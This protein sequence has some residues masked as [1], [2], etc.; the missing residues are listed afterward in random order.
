MAESKKRISKEEYYLNI[1]DAVGA[2]GTC[3]RRN[4][5]AIIVKA[6]NIIATGY[7][8][9]PR[10]EANC[11][12]VCKCE[13]EVLNIPSGE[14]YELCKSV[15]AE[16]NCIISASRLD[17]I[18]STLYLSGRDANTGELLNAKPCLMCEKM[19]KN[20]GIARVIARQADGSYMTTEVV[21]DTIMSMIKQKQ[22]N[23]GV[24]SSDTKN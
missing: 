13:R 6:D 12:D 24:I 21:N 19:I 3:L 2:R 17:M 16:Q 23:H 15:H 9:S 20:A 4:Y 14:R 7:T 8:G 11:C 1:A 10:G 22:Q 18:G 5:G